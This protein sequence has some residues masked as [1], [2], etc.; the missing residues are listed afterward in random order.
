[1]AI[2]P[3][4]NISDRVGEGFLSVLFTDNSVGNPTSY[5][6]IFG[7]GDVAQGPESAVVHTYEEPGRYTVILVVDDGVDQES[8]IKED[9]IIVNRVHCVPQFV[10][11]ESNEQDANLY[12]KY[13]VDD[14][15]RLVFENQDVIVRSVNPVVNLNEWTLVEYHPF[16]EKMFVATSS[17]FRKEENTFKVLNGSPLVPDGVS[18][19]VAKNSTMQIDELK[20]W[21]KYVS[22]SDYYS[23]TRSKAALLDL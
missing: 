9:L 18:F 23:D 10:I 13:Y 11:A 3:D 15:M 21:K 4:F 7:D 6:W 22:L 5:K 14:Q 1:M 16:I 19:Q 2:T 17:V 12:W 20:I 8:I